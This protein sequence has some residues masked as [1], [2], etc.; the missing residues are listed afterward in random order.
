M[1]HVKHTPLDIGMRA[2]NFS[3]VL[4]ETTEEGRLFHIGIYLGEKISS[5]HHY[6]QDILC[7]ES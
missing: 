7:S 4:D 5:G 1:L 3:G 2:F 6:K